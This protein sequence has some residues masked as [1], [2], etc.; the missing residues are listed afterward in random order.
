MYHVLSTSTRGVDIG[1]GV[2]PTEACQSSMTCF[3]PPSDDD[4]D[5]RNQVSTL[6]SSSCIWVPLLLLLLCC[7]VFPSP[8]LLPVG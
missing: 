2:R 4:D 1:V 3:P 8:P 6:S 5:Q 7:V